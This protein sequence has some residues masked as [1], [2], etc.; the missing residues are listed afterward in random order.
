[1]SEDELKSVRYGPGNKIYI[2]EKDVEEFLK[3]YYEY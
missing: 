1:V 3:K 2:A